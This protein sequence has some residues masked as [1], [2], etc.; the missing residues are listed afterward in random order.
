MNG[1]VPPPSE[2][3]EA[4]KELA[5]GAT[6]GRYVV[7]ALIGRGGMG[8][9]YAAYDPELDRK[10]AVKLL[11]EKGGAGQT[12]TAGRM[13]LLREAQAI[14]RLHH[15]NVVVV[16]DIGTFNESVFIAM[17]FVEGNTVR[18]WSEARARGWREVLDVFRAAGQ[19]LVAAHEAGLVHRDFK[20]EN[21]MI[22][23]DGQVRVMDFGLARRVVDNET[24]GEG[25]AELAAA[26]NRAVDLGIR[27]DADATINLAATKASPPGSATGYLQAKLTETGAVMG[28]PAYMA[29]E[30]FAG[31]HGDARADQFSFSVALYE[32]LYGQRPFAGDT[33]AALMANIVAGNI[34]PPP[35]QSRVPAWIR[36]VLLR[37][38][39]ALPDGRFPSMA[40]LLTALGQDPAVRNRR[41]IG[42]A[43]AALLIAGAAVG[44]RRFS[45]G[46]RTICAGGPSHAAAVWGPET[47]EA[48]R[49]AFANSGN[50]RASQAFAAAAGLLDTYLDHWIGMYTAACEATHARGEQSAE[51]LDL[52]MAC[53]DERLSSVRVLTDVLSHADRGVVDSAIDAAS[54]LP[55]LDRCADV[56]MLRAVIKPPDDRAT[57]ARVAAVRETVAKV[58][59]L[60]MSGQCDKAVALGNKAV[61]D[62]EAVG[63]LPLKAEALL[64]LGALGDNCMDPLKAIDCL[65]DA[66]FAAE[67]SHHDEVAFRAAVMIAPFFSD[68]IR[69][70]RMARFWV[71]YAEAILTRFPG[72]P[73]FE[74][75]LAVSRAV[76]FEFNGLYDEEIREH[77]RA[78]DIK[79][80]VLGS[81]HI[82]TAISMMDLAVALHDDGRD[83]QAEPIMARA[84]A[85]FVD[86]CGPDSTRVALASLDLSEILT[87]LRRFE[88]AHNAID[89]AIAIW[90]AK[91]GS[92]FFIGYALM[93]LGRLNLAEGH[94]LAARAVLE[95]AVATLGKDAPA[96]TAEAQFALAKTLWGSPPERARAVDLARGARAVL[97]E[98]KLPPRKTAEI[99]AWL[100]GHPA[101]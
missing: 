53:L 82:D 94:P 92:T 62:A 34:R 93:D 40:A 9:V 86:L 11:R 6:I 42:V 1:P 67:A 65:E 30:Q 66:V 48:V 91:G 35:P 8:D 77:Q 16:Y 32:A 43:A 25:A 90:K 95:Q 100:V 29:P 33:L 76:V 64:A 21:V 36:R 98:G 45:A 26:L 55:T 57:R 7:L 37:G 99:D 88:G 59:V 38:I 69:D 46:Q 23:N 27:A 18:Y 5:K 44:A 83:A 2:T 41:W 51:V 72:H 73:L 4:A 19:G 52:R 101:R 84:I 12:T 70:L 10:I 31:K 68:R 79:L 20:P 49:R 3:S 87:G 15:P 80:S 39:S 58:N 89:R 97:S 81:S 47:R 74:A 78:L 28:T 56:A 14:A 61:A 17:E 13:R 60:G 75:W 54:G 63:Y 85:L 50:S 71:R 24:L 22:T 96:V